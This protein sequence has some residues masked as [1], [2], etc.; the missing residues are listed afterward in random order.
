MNHFKTNGIAGKGILSTQLTS[1]LLLMLSVF[2]L[3]TAASAAELVTNGGFEDPV[4][5]TNPDTGFG[6][7]TYYGE[8]FSGPADCTAPQ[9][10]NCN[11]GTLVPGWLVFWTDDLVNAEQ[12]NPGRIELQ[13]GEITPFIPPAYDGTAQKAELDSHHR[14]NESGERLDNN[15]VTIAQVLPTCPLTGYTLNYAWKSRTTMK[16]DN[17]VRV[18]INLEQ[19]RILGLNDDWE[20]ETEYFTSDNSYET[21]LL[22]GSIGTES[23]RGMYLDEVS[24]TGPDGSDPGNCSL[25]CDD[26]PFELTLRYD[27][28]EDSDNN[29][30][31]NEVI[32][33]PED[34]E[35]SFPAHATIKVFG[36]QWKNPMLLGTFE[37]VP[38]DGFFTVSGP[39]KRIPPRMTFEIW[40]DDATE[41]DLPVQTVTFHTSCSQPL[42]AG[43]EFGAITVWSAEN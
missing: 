38:I 17:D 23:T 9:L 43:D 31:G 26:K 33:I 41:G 13:R 16:G 37:D 1:A 19:L 12:A 25:V 21:L 4:V 6:W 5:P 3:T 40:D 18:F 8:N 39:K 11:D 2:T 10:N 14:V 35:G 32:I 20:E 42:D 30:S 28:D 36:H 15:N 34:V 27:G 24:V 22:F 29:Q 7:M